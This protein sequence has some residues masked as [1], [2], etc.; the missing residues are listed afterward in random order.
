MFC[1]SFVMS[2]ESETLGLF[3]V[4]FFEESIVLFETISEFLEENFSEEEI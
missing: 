1:F 2:C 4:S 3:T